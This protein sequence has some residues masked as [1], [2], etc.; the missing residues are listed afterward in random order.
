M[1]Y[2]HG[3]IFRR[4][5]LVPVAYKKPIGAQLEKPNEEE[6]LTPVESAEYAIPIVLVIKRD[7]GARLYSDYK[8]TLNQH[9]K[10]VNYPCRK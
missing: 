4:A 6:I 2:K 10:E 3:R 1:E 7:G 9:L 8:T 5:R